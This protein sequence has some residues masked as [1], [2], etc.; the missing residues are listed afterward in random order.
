MLVK[1][2]S[3]KELM[4]LAIQSK[5]WVSYDWRSYINDALKPKL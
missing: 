5:A 2:Y 3:Y 4:D 1:I